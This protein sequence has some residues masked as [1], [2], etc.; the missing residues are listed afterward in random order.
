MNETKEIDALKTRIRILEGCLLRLADH[1]INKGT[2]SESYFP[3]DEVEFY[4]RLCNDDSI[5][6]YEDL[7]K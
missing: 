5:M 2:H 7:P 6:M 4:A 1:V 3:V